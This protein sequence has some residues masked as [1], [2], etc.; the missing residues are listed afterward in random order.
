MPQFDHLYN[1][2]LK[3]FLLLWGKVGNLFMI[4]FNIQ[5]KNCVLFEEIYV[6]GTWE[7]GVQCNGIQIKY[8]SK[9]ILS[10]YTFLYKINKKIGRELGLAPQ[11]IVVVFVKPESKS[12][13]PCPNR[14]KILT[15][16][17]EQ[18]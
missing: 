1:P 10:F 11:P 15:L 8:F 2:F 12:P 17:S 6:F 18:V 3:I 16:R 13:I 14:P 5:G 4:F 7:K 9:N